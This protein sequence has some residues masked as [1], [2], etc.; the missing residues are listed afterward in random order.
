M[1]LNLTLG[2]KE[3][4]NLF[5]GWEVQPSA[6]L[7]FRASDHQT[8]WVSVTRAVRIPSQ[9]E[10]DFRLTAPISVSP[11]FEFLVSG[12][13][14]FRPETLLGYEAGY[15]QLVGSNFYIDVA[16]FFN[17]Y[18]QLQG[19]LPGVVQQDPVANPPQP[20]LTILYGNTVKGSTRGIEFSPDWKVTSRWR[21]AGSY[22]LLRYNLRSRDGFSDPASI[23]GY[24]G[25]TPLH[26][27]SFQSRL[28]LGGRFEFDQSLRHLGSLP[29]QM[30]PAYTTAD[31][32]L[33][34]HSANLDLSVVGKDLIDNGH[35]EFGSGDGQVPTLGVRRSVFGKIV[36]TSKP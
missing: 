24:V 34:W 18:D 5:S 25:S 1:R 4:H 12:N 22:S 9:L 6:R 7:L 21:L 11:P 10:E 35:M 28:D 17:Q 27:I 3:E 16:G 32:R 19:F 13:K 15:R 29:A 8:Y 31:L 26:Q 23:T 30:V 33:G 2:V 36:W 14:N 20:A